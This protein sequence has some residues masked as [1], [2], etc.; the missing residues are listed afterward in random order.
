M[1]TT[2]QTIPDAD[3][4]RA[5]LAAMSDE[6]LTE[7]LGPIAARLAENGTREMTTAT[8]A[9]DRLNIDMLEREAAIGELMFK[10][11]DDAENLRSTVESLDFRP[12]LPVDLIGRLRRFAAMAELVDALDQLM[13][14]TD[15]ETASIL[16]ALV[17][18]EQGCFD[19]AEE[20]V[21]E[22][23]AEDP[24]RPEWIDAVKVDAR[25]A[26]RRRDLI[27][28]VLQRVEAVA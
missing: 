19:I 7:A 12:K 13:V 27:G 26:R 25:A 17:A 24:P 14:P 20:S 5:H 16:A 6:Q 21:R 18:G 8:P 3:A 28:D 15:A 4:V 23:E 22:A 11:V 1:S 2:H 10:I 9:V